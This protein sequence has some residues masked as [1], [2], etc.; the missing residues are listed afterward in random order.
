[1]YDAE[2]YQRVML[3]NKEKNKCHANKVFTAKFVSGQN[4][5]LYSGGWD[6]NVKIWDI[7][8]M[9]VTHN[10]NG[11][12]ISGDSVDMAEDGKTLLTGGGTSGEGLQI[13]DLRN[14]SC[15]KLNISWSPYTMLP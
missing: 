10:I 9:S 8:A 11:P 3:L 7:R 4:N 14:T 13:W 12:M 5:Q 6:K 2:T 15:P 1:M